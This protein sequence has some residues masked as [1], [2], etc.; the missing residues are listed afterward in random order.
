MPFYFIF[1]K[2]ALWKKAKLGMSATY[3]PFFS[4]GRNVHRQT[5]EETANANAAATTLHSHYNNQDSSEDLN[6][7]E[8][9]QDVNPQSRRNVQSGK[10]QL[11]VMRM[12]S[13]EYDLLPGT[14]GTKVVN[15]FHM[16]LMICSK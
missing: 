9:H 15:L 2:F 10:E 4:F 14:C 12:G 5:S 11:G 13:R 8:E 7:K 1:Y 3:T 16:G 6:G